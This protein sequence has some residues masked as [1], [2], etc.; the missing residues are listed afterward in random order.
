ML[1]QELLLSGSLGALAGEQ[2]EALERSHT[3]ARHLLELVQDVLD[4]SRIEAGS[5]SLHPVE[6]HLP[7]L[8]RDL[9]DTMLP[10]AQRYG[11][12]I[13]LRIEPGLQ[14]L[15]TD[16]QRVRQVLLNLLSN[17]AKFGRGRPIVL[18]CCTNVYG[19]TSIEVEDRGI[20]IAEADLS[21][22]FE[23]FVQVGNSHDG[24]GLGLAIS[25]RLAYLLKGRL[26]VESELGRGSTFRL[27]LPSSHA[28]HRS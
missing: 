20:G 16:P 19:E 21:H 13:E 11:S 25:R 18:S 15:V 9:R 5:V 23:D 8:L 22:I 2:Q 14:T 10:V 1:H 24:I 26:E 27:V 6:V 12:E 3:A 4:L 28:G 7:A 17:A